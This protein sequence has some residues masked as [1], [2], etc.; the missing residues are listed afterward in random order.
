MTNT[1][2]PASPRSPRAG[3]W[4][5]FMALARPYWVSNERWSA[6]GLLLLVVTLAF[7]NV[8]V[9]VRFNRLNADLFNALQGMSLHGFFR[10]M[11][12][13]AVWIAVYI[14]VYVYQQYLTQA[15]GLRWR[16]WMT[17]ALL[18][19]WLSDRTYYYWH[20]VGQKT[21]NPD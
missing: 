20:L 6:R 1:K 16:R 10:A 4:R 18:T 12:G 21:D 19:R 8:Y 15:L 2:K 14:L 7:G 3:F 17:E 13:F 11:L 5:E 9:S